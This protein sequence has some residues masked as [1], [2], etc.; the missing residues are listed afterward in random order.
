MT[1]RGLDGAST[2]TFLQTGRISMTLADEGP[3]HHGHRSHGGVVLPAGVQVLPAARPR[4][5]HLACS[6]SRLNWTSLPGFT[7]PPGS[8]HSSYAHQALQC[9]QIS[10]P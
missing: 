2:A 6:L 5:D 9:R 3:V 8:P 10:A 7:C 1:W 4:A